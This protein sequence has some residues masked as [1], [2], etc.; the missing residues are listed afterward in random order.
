MLKLK[1]GAM[2]G[3]EGRVLRKE[4]GRLV[5]T[6]LR[7]LTFR[8]V[9]GQQAS[10]KLTA[11]GAMFGLDARIALAIFGA[12]SVISG[13]ALYS[14]IQEAKVTQHITQSNNIVMAVEQYLLDTGEIVPIKN[15]YDLDMTAL[16]EKPTG[17]TGWN[18]PYINFEKDSG[19]DFKLVNPLTQKNI[20]LSY[21]NGSDWADSTVA[22]RACTQSTAKCNVYVLY[23]TTNEMFEKLE[24]G[25]DGDGSVGY[26]TGKFRKSSSDTFVNAGISFDPKNALLP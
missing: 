9:E 10:Q 23:Q 8:L 19:S 25:Y 2:F 24:E 3:I 20:I 16:V 12:L 13:A 7:K 6:S 4:S 22:S 5:L 26:L 21:S 11:K 18:G 15:N 1:K 17:V 14:A